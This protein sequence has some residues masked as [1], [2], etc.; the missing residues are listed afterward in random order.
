MNN[1]IVFFILLLI[2]I[3]YIYA[4]PESY[5]NE[6]TNVVY[7]WS[8]KKIEHLEN[9]KKYKEEILSENPKIV[10]IHNF[11]TEE[12]ANHI[13]KLANE[14]KKPSTIDS[15]ESPVTLSANIRSSNTAH[16]G[17]SR[18]IIVKNIEQKASNYTNLNINYIE[19]LQVAVYEKGQKYNPHYDFF[20]THS[21]VIEQYGNRTKTILVYLNDLSDNAGGNTYFPKLDLRVKP[22]ALDAIYFENM[23]NGN[24]NY[25]TLHAGEEI[26]NDSKKYAINIWFREKQIN[27]AN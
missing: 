23:S 24:L 25:D 3:I 18:D 7:K 14:L 19:P 22:K 16:L 27:F 26:L 13:I 11:I 1:I 2:Y 15:K 5:T 21:N 9:T 17:K 6:I 20:D 8:N 12:E 4:K 10:Y